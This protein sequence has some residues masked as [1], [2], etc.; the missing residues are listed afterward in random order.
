MEKYYE[1][2]DRLNG[3][4]RQCKCGVKLSRYNPMELCE[5]CQEKEKKDNKKNTKEALKHVNRYA[6]KTYKKENSRRRLQ[7]K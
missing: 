1:K 5:V 7:H 6:L 4:N 3:K 2:K